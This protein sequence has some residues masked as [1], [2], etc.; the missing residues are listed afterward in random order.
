MAVL[1]AL[2]RSR[3]KLYTRR[4]ELRSTV[5]AVAEVVEVA[6]DSTVE[7]EPWLQSYLKPLG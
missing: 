1:V 4:P 2:P 7:E 5:A 6:E 3:A